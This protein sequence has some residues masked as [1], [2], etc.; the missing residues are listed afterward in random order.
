MSKELTVA[1]DVFNYP[2]NRESPGWGE[3][4]SSWA[5]AVTDVLANVAGEGDILQTSAS[6]SNNIAA[7]TSINGFAF[8]P[9]VV[10]GAVAEFSIYRV[11][12]ETSLGAADGQERVETGVLYIGSKSSAGSFEMSQAGSGGSGVTLSITSAG[13]IQYTSDSMTGINH[14]GVIKFR[15][16]ALTI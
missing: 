5:E 15:A 8:D 2:E 11:T 7:L 3:E 12:L 6:L 13:Q 1:G 14:S 16:R 4:A 9:A 10:R